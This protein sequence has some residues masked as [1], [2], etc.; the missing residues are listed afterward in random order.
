MF[1]EVEV[2]EDNI[3]RCVDVDVQSKEI[4]FTGIY[5]SPR[6]IDVYKSNDSEVVVNKTSGCLCDKRTR[7]LKDNE[8]ISLSPGG[9]LFLLQSVSTYGYD[10]DAKFMCDGLKVC[11]VKH[12][13]MDG[14][15]WLFVSNVSGDIV[16]LEKDVCLFKG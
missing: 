15:T 14:S 2:I 6:G 9:M 3:F 11:G 4:M 16:K 12:N 5:M 10:K 1:K 7:F 8:T 13:V